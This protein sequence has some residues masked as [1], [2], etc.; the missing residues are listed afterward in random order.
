MF[1]AFA[2]L[3]LAGAL[4][5]MLQK[6]VIEA[7]LSMALS[8]FGVAGLFVLLANPVAGALQIIVYAGAILVLVLFVIMLLNA[9]EEEPAEKARPFQRY[10]GLAVAALIGLTLIRFV[11]PS[12]ALGQLAKGPVAQAPMTLDQVGET[13]L[14]SHLLSFEVVGLVLLAAMVGAVALTKKDL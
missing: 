11:L 12:P 4:A 2:L 14:R 13:L 10:V 5:M 3:T 8:F 6:N 7:G 9:H 1:F